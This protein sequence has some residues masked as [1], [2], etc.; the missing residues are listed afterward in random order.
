MKWFYGKEGSVFRKT[1]DG[2]VSD[3]IELTIFLLSKSN[4][5]MVKFIKENRIIDNINE[6]N[7]LS[8]E[9]LN[10][11]PNFEYVINPSG[12]SYHKIDGFDVMYIIENTM[13]KSIGLFGIEILMK[14]KVYLKHSVGLID[15]DMLQEIKEK[16]ILEIKKDF[17]NKI[18]MEDLKGEK[19]RIIMNY[20]KF[21]EERKL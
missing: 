7:K 11:I 4:N 15:N 6:T 2:G 19:F 8:Y 17:K 18:E 14:I 12:R 10:L 20:N 13:I 16:I 5:Y 21:E 1:F 9:T 3:D